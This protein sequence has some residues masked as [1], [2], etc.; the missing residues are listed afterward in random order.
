MNKVFLHIMAILLDPSY[1]ISPTIVKTV[2]L[3][4]TVDPQLSTTM[5]GRCS[6]GNSKEWVNDKHIRSF[7]TESNPI[8]MVGPTKTL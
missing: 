4:S 3:F 5:V 8:L 7:P 1:F 6:M 2:N